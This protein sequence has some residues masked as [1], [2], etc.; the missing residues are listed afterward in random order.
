MP[1]APHGFDNLFYLKGTT[2][3]LLHLGEIKVLLT[4][5]RGLCS[6]SCWSGFDLVMRLVVVV[7]I[8]Y[9]WSAAVLTVAYMLAKDGG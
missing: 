5:T 3:D 1:L 8:G 2:I 6:P 4:P 9:S 7:G